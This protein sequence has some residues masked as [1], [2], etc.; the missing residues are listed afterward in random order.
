MYI[1]Y[2]QQYMDVLL[3][4]Y[5]KRFEVL[6]INQVIMTDVLKFLFLAIFFLSS[7]VAVYCVYMLQ[8]NR[9]LCAVVNSYAFSIAMICLYLYPFL[10]NLTWEHRIHKATMNWIVWLSV[11]TEVVFQI[12]HN[13]FVKQLHE[14][15]GTPIEW[16]FYSYGLSDSRWS[17]YHGGTGLAPEVWLINVNDAFFGILVG[18]FYIWYLRSL[19]KSPFESCKVKVMFAIIVLF[20][21][22]TLWRETV[23]YL[24]DHYRKGYPYT[25]DLVG[26]RTHAIACLW[27]VN[28]IW[29]VAPC[30]S[31]LWT[32]NCI[33][34]LISTSA[35]T[36]ATKKAK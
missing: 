3:H 33:I 26:Y 17:N 35:A 31:S 14:A 32:Y 16:P 28:I 34:E 24:W 30:I 5:L 36:R 20:R 11:F 18:L 15:E 27:T 9:P 19:N 1:Q 10:S 22:A 2:I 29:L 25:T 8:Y 13:L 6:I 23:E 12:P 21:D 7:P 4:F